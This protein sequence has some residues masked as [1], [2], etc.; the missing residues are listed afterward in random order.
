MKKFPF[1]SLY[2][3]HFFWAD[4]YDLVK[5]K[6]DMPPVLWRDHIEKVTVDLTVNNVTKLTCEPVC[7]SPNLVVFS[8]LSEDNVLSLHSDELVLLEL[9]QGIGGIIMLPYE[10]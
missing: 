5:M 9:S 6:T 4:V 3:Y 2:L 8:A 7:S 1:Y 10:S